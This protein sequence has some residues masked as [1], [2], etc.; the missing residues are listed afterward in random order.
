MAE[1]KLR[2]ISDYCKSTT[3]H[4]SWYMLPAYTLP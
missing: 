3:N 1:K 4:L 2:A